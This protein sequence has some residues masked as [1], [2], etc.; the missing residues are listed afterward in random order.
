MLNAQTHWRAADAVTQ[1]ASMHRQLW[2]MHVLMAMLEAWRVCKTELQL[3]TLIS[4][5]RAI[6]AGANVPLPGRSHQSSVACSGVMDDG[7][8]PPAANRNGLRRDRRTDTGSPAERPIVSRS[9]A[10]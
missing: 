6:K 5:R 8:R 7:G 3:E 1:T 10:D 9:G 4:H 2:K